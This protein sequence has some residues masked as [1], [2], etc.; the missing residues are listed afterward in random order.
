MILAHDKKRE[1]LRKARPVA[2]LIACLLAF[3]FTLPAFAGDRLLVFAAAS[4]KDALEAA[5]QDYM[6]QSGDSVVFSF[7]ASSVL[8]KQIAAGAPANLFVSANSEWVDW[9]E[10]RGFANRDSRRDIAGNRLVIAGRARGEGAAVGLELLRNGKFA[11]GDPTHV[12]AGRYAR[13][14]LEQL[15]IWEMVQANAVYGENARVALE[16]V[17]RGEL[18]IAIVY[19]SDLAVS[20]GLT[21]LFEFPESSHPPI[22]YPAVI[23]AGA[24]MKAARFTEFLAGPRG[25]AILARFGFLP[26]GG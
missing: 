1:P 23:P 4:M 18:D 24:D 17:R 20:T 15:G 6:E 9:L 26:A 5:G 16:Y 11:M 14:A 12:P 21:A 8:A 13:A 25:Q 10:E 2:A 19:R 3:Y 7:A 22:V